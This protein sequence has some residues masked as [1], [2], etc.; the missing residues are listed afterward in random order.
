MEGVVAVDDVEFSW[1]LVSEPQWTTEHGYR[2]VRISVQLRDASCREL[3]L[4]YPMPKKMVGI[5]LPQLP[6]RPTV[7]VTM[8][9]DGIRKAIAAGWEPRSRGKALLFEIGCCD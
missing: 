4:Q 2:G 7:T 6:Q 1:E 8:I 5:G 9:E 3:L